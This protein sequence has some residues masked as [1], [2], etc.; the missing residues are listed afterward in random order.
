ME[1]YRQIH[2]FKGLF[3][4]L[5][6]ILTPPTLQALEDRLK[7]LLN[8]QGMEDPAL[9]IQALGLQEIEE[10]LTRIA[11]FYFDTW[12]PRFFPTKKPTHWT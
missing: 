8:P 1:I 11:P 5:D 2:T 9:V 6:L 7:T 12:G 10:S 4:Q 3:L